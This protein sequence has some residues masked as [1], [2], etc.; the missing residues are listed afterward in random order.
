MSFVFVNPT[1]DLYKDKAARDAAWQ[2]AHN[3]LAS[4]PKDGNIA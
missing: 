4:E 2:L 1:T 3:V